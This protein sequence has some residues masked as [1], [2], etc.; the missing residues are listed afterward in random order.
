MVGDRLKN[1]QVWK[2]TLPAGAD[3]R[4]GDRLLVNGVT[5]AVEAILAGASV[6]VER[7]TYCSKAP[8]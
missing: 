7:V 3:V 8:A 1:V 2:I 4:L 6:E 5:Y